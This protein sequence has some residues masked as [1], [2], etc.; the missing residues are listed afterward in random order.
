MKKSLKRWRLDINEIL[1]C[2]QLEYP[3]RRKKCE[4]NINQYTLHSESFSFF[5]GIESIQIEIIRVNCQK[6]IQLASR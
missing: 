5:F 2:Q 6:L 4:K 1:T 3:S